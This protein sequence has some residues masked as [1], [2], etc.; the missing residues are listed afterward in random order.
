MATK[1][2]LGSN[3]ASIGSDGRWSRSQKQTL[4]ARS[5]EVDSSWVNSISYE[6]AS[7]NLITNLAGRTYVYS[8]V[9]PQRYAAL[10]AADSKGRYVN[11]FIKPNYPVRRIA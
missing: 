11:Q 3:F 10:C 8:G 2:F 7:Q 5:C 4:G 1:P 9:S 6:P